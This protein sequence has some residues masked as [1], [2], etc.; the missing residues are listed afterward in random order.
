MLAIVVDMYE[1]LIDFLGAMSFAQTVLN[2]EV[3]EKNFFKK[4]QIFQ[5]ILKNFIAMDKA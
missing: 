5:G 4:F 3:F 1:W 2:L